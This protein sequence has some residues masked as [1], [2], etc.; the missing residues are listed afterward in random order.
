MRKVVI[1]GRGNGSGLSARAGVRDALGQAV[2]ERSHHRSRHWLLGI[3]VVV[4]A[5]SC[6]G[7]DPTDDLPADCDAYL[8][9]SRDCFHMDA[10]RIKTLRESYHARLVAA[11]DV[12]KRASIVSECSRG[13]A[14]LSKV[15]RAN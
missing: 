12:D 8:D 11:S 15:C 10:E 6:A 3:A 13:V 7:G 14:Q 4:L 2:F 5:F 1:G 9:T